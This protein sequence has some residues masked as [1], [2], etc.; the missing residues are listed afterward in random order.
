MKVRDVVKA[1]EDNGW[2]FARRGGRSS[3]RIY[4]KEGVRAEV[5]IS[6]EDS[7]DVTPGQLQDIR[8]KSGLPLR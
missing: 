8:R 3:H 2:E 6:G 4:K 5:S 7:K 1:L